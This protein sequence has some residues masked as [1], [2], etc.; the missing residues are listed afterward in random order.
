MAKLSEGDVL[1]SIFAIIIGSVVSQ[2]RVDKSDINSFR[3]IAEPSLFSSGSYE[4]FLVKDAKRERGSNPA[5]IFNVSLSINLKP[6]QDNKYKILYGSA[7]EIGNLNDKIDQLVNMASPFKMP[8]IAKI[9]K[10]RDSY[11][12]NSTQEG[13]TFTVSADGSSGTIDSVSGQVTVS[14]SAQIAE[15]EPQSIISETIPFTLR[16]EQENVESFDRM[17]AIAN[18]FEIKWKDVNKYSDVKKKATTSIERLK[19]TQILREMC[20]DMVRMISQNKIDV[21]KRTYSFL[22]QAPSLVKIS[23]QAQAQ[24]DDLAEMKK[25]ITL[26]AY[27]SGRNITIKDAR[28]GITY[29]VLKTIPRPN[30]IEFR[31]E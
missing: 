5:D 13:I 27:Q 30:E 11:L 24:L 20:D 6:Q 25:T 2:G 12:D 22:T 10:A 18:A 3:S 14:M 15:E 26:S 7:S 4:G 1:E 28:K 19:R 9:I 23:P 31:L 8:Q 17:L 29:F 21:S 16:T